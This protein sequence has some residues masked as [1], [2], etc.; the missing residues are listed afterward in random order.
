MWTKTIWLAA[1]IALAGTAPALALCNPGTKNC[2]PLGG[3]FLGKAQQQVNQGNG[4]FNCDPTEA[5]A[6][7]KDLPGSSARTTTTGVSPVAGGGTVAV[8]PSISR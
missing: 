7:S 2:I 8:A 5:G 4:N 3:G 6:C 1:V